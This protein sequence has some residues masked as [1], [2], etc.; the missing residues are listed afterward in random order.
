MTWQR[1]DPSNAMMPVDVVILSV[2]VQKSSLALQPPCYPLSPCL[3]VRDSSTLEFHCQI[4]GSLGSRPEVDGKENAPSVSLRNYSR[5]VTVSPYRTAACKCAPGA[6][7]RESI[8]GSP[9]QF[10]SYRAANNPGR[11]IC[12]ASGSSCRSLRGRPPALQDR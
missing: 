8:H 4:F 5:I 6:A 7:G 11:Q 9:S 3:H 12:P 10:G 1:N 2:T